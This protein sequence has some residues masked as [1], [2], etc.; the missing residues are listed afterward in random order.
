MRLWR[1]AFSNLFLYHMGFILVPFTIPIAWPKVSVLPWGV[2]VLSTDSHTGT[3][4]ELYTP[5]NLF[6]PGF[7]QSMWSSRDRTT[8]GLQPSMEKGIFFWPLTSGS[9]ASLYHEFTVNILLFW[10]TDWNKLIIP[11]F[12]QYYVCVIMNLEIPFQVFM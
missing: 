10:F 3:E 12:H 9:K 1:S 4:V 2:A 7:S 6:I 5:C 8:A 11:L